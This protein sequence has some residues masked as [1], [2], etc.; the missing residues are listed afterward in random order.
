MTVISIDDLEY[1]KII[2]AAPYGML[3]IE[4]DDGEQLE[5]HQGFVFALGVHSWYLE[6]T[7]FLGKRVEVVRDSKSIS[8]CSVVA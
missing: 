1:G 6:P 2:K 5:I 7:E 8:W 3:T 4:M